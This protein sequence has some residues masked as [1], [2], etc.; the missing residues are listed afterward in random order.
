MMKIKD[1]LM[2]IKDILKG[3]FLVQKQSYHN[4]N[5][6]IFI[7]FL[8][9]MSITSSHIMDQEIRKITKINEEIKELKSEYASIQ[10]RYLRIKLVSVLKQSTKFKHVETAPYEVIIEK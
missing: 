8:S 7:T 9:L 5:F 2:N 6:I 3:K 4:W 1:I 10:S